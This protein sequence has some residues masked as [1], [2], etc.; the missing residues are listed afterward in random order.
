MATKRA[1]KPF[2]T[3]EA[4]P[5]QAMERYR[6]LERAIRRPRDTE[7]HL[8][9][10]ESALGMYMLAHYFGWKV[11]YLLHSKRTI[12]KYEELLG[13]KLS[14]NFPEFGDDADRTNAYKAIQAVS[15]FWKLV[16]GEEK[17]PAGLDK[18]LMDSKGI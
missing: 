16:S 8:P 11:P 6:V 2:K 12:K 13:L 7:T 1:H 10:L 15:N 4:T 9:E 3:P 18:R 14:E 5:E 17:L